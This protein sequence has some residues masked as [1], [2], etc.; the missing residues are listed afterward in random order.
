MFIERLQREVET[1]TQAPRTELDDRIDEF[2]GLLVGGNLQ[3]WL[4]LYYGAI[5]EETS[6]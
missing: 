6:E 5:S 3:E 2:M 1:G 4:S